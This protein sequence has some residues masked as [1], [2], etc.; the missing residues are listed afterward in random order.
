M[1]SSFSSSLAATNA[2][3]TNTTSS[4]PTS[5]TFSP[6]SSLLIIGSGVFGL[7]TAWALSRR[8]AFSN[9][10]ITVV[11]R[12]D[13]N[14]NVFP[15]SD[16][17]S[18]DTSR[19]VRADYADPA[20]AALGAEAQVLWRQ[21]TSPTDLGACGRYHESGLLL[22]A[23]GVPPPPN[24]PPRP[25][26]ID[27]TKLTG[28]DY[29]R[30]SW[31]NVL[32]LAAQNPALA[33][34]V[35]ETPDVAAIRAEARTGGGS[36]GAWG[37]I[38]DGSGW[39]DAGA[40]MAWLYQQV[41]QTGRVTFVAG[42]VTSLEHKGSAV[43][44]AKLSDGRVLSADLV[45]LAAGA[46]TAS[47]LDISG[48]AVATGQVLGYLDITEAEQAQLSNMPT[49]LNLSSGLFIIPPRNRVLKI[50]RHAYGYL[51]PTVPQTE[52]LPQS[53]SA[54]ATFKCDSQQ[55]VSLPLT[56]AS[57]PT[58]SIPAEGAED[59]RAA[60][61]EMVPLPALWDRPFTKTRLCWY[62]DTPTGDFVVDYHPQ[63]QNLFVAF[64][65]SGHAFKFMPVIGDKTA[66]CIMKSCPPEFK[67]KWHWKPA[68]S[69]TVVTEDGT[70][71]GKPGLILAEALAQR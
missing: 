70:R 43:T 46:W 5:S 19:I 33:G 26:I 55:S 24:T 61:R 64:G 48:Q 34:Q 28:M 9:C 35:R 37:Y 59:L 41:K 30:Y 10:S 40:S 58:L 56:S 47:L 68:N 60:L 13:P 14:T 6:P 57:D 66:D 8:P 71:G 38:N 54:A 18:V 4:P 39:A 2:T 12:S 51:N 11:D 20:Y 22:V 32:Q 69:S 3:T 1:D 29:A 50:A 44:G 15:A 67:G 42:T 27:K 36:S 52:P 63:W 25:A 23:D 17:A 49:I 65:D 53:P 7:G 21:Q 31:A 45:M 16:A 62:S